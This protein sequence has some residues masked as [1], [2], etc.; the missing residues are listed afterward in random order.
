MI[1]VAQAIDFSNSESLALL[2]GFIGL[3]LAAPALLAGYLVSKS[4]TVAYRKLYFLALS[5]FLLNLT[6]FGLLS[7]VGTRFTGNNLIDTS[8]WIFWTMLIVLAVSSL[9]ILTSLFILVVE[10]FKNRKSISSRKV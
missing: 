5:I 10:W 1:Y 7:G 8:S 4:K 6:T 2:Q 9:G 3:C